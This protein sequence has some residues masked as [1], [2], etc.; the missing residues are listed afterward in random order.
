MG[1][2]KQRANSTSVE[3]NPPT[4][5]PNPPRGSRWQLILSG[6]L[7]LIWLFFLAWMAFAS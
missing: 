1:V 4:L 2:R 5:T 7:L 6:F 3:A